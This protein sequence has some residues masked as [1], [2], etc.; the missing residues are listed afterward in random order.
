MPLDLPHA[1]EI[2]VSL[3]ERALPMSRL[4]FQDLFTC[5]PSAILCLDHD[6]N[7]LFANQSAIHL[8]GILALIGKN[9]FTLFPGNLK[10]PFY[11]SYRNAMEKRIET[12]FEA[13]Y[14]EPLNTWFKA[15]A[16]P[17]NAGI[18]I[19]FD[20]ISERKMAEFARDR[21]ARLLEQVF[22]VT[23]DAIVTIDRNWR[24]TFVNRRAEQIL[25]FKND[26]VGKNH[27]EEF[28]AAA[29]TS[30][31]YWD[32]YHRAM[33]DRSTQEFEAFY[34]APLDRFFFVQARPSDDGIV[35][36]FRDITDRRLWE[37]EIHAQ[38]D[39]L[40]AVQ[41]GALV[42]TWSLDPATGHIEYGTGSYPVFGHPFEEVATLPSLLAIIPPAHRDRVLEV[43][44]AAAKDR[45]L[46]TV[47]FEVVAKDGSRIC[48]E[49]RGQ[50]LEERGK[51]LRIGGIAIDIS[52]RK[53]AAN[54][55]LIEQQETER[56]RAEIETIY[57]TAEIGL[58]L[59]SVGDFRYLRVNE[60]QAQLIG[61]PPD[62]IIG[63]TLVEIAPNVPGLEAIFRSVEAGI[64]VRDLVLEGELPSRPGEPRVWSV[65]YTP[66]IGS[67]GS[68]EAIAAAS[69]EITHQKQAE[70][71]LLHS[72]KL[73]AVGRLASSIS[74]EI[75]NPLESVTN[76][77]YIIGMDD[78]LPT[79]LRDYLNTAQEELARV[80]QIATQTLRFHRQAANPTEV[81]PAALVDAVL[82]LYHGRLFNSG[83]QVET[84]YQTVAPIICFEN[85][86]RQV[87]NNL[88]ANAI[89]AM[90]G[91][92]RLLARAH[93]SRDPQTGR[94]RVRISIADTG[95]G[96]SRATQARI[97]DPFFTTKELNGTGL[98]LWISTDIVRRHH[99]MLRV[100]SS[101]TAGHRGT[102]FTLVLP[103]DEVPEEAP[104]P[105]AYAV[106]GAS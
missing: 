46:F 57:Q 45:S 9:I 104:N 34:P 50:V 95:H 25:A 79:E 82:D 65:S 64:P 61:L 98:G 86:L 44:R 76:L 87:L 37:Q 91:G 106:P 29:D 99:G 11:S 96:M 38:Q 66:V 60:R 6:Y 18:A 10:E 63:R 13:F 78:S 20:D 30:R 21:S 33:D 23:T 8:T 28:P 43:T 41:Q 68:V 74:H 32:A 103:C 31:P 52:E 97:F 36:F 7:I 16:R 58:A 49:C 22:E 2:P 40:G 17:F 27:W 88:I 1:R 85:D 19:F 59:F 73:A 62:Q 42:A 4:Q 80:S 69:L 102:V 15:T 77:L 55:L 92:G 101:R 90:E 12:G 14:A 24:I 5:L 94:P 72:E 51:T 53:R 47:E 54:A 26:L 81:T 35:L 67:D 48:V 89:D 105:S 3:S 39:L 84:R 100:R 70:A 93:S 71:A 75:N 83:I 56:Q